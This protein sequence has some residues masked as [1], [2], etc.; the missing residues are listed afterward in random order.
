[1]MRRLVST[2]KVYDCRL[3]RLKDVE[4]PCFTLTAW[5]FRFEDAG[6]LGV[7]YNGGEDEALVD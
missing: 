4:D 7:C 3:E 6:K 2:I 1:M 5:G